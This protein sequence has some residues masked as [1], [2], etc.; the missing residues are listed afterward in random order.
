VAHSVNVKS[1]TCCPN[2]T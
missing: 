1:T 2:R